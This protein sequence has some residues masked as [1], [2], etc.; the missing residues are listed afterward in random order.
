MPTNQSE[1]DKTVSEL[2]APESLSD[3]EKFNSLLVEMV[4]DQ[5]PRVFAVVIEHG[6]REDAA[7]AAWGIAFEDSA[8]MVTANGNNHYSLAAAENALNY[9][10]IDP[11]TTPHLVWSNPTANP[12]ETHY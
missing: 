6:H 8:Y 9:V 10:R 2:D 1:A 3:D 5:A 7:I 12:P 11:R 4:A